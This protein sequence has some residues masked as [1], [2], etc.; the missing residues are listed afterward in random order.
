MQDFVR[1]VFPDL[2][3]QLKGLI[4]ANIYLLQLLLFS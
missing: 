1:S 3:P 2:H 4:L